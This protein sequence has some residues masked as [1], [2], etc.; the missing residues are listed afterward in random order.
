[1]KI[2]KFLSVL[3]TVAVVMI[4]SASAFA[5]DSNTAKVASAAT[6]TPYIVGIGD[7]QA[8]AISLVLNEYGGV[9]Y[10]LFIQSSTDSDWFKWTNTS[11]EFKR[12]YVTVGGFSGNGPTRAGLKI[13]YN[14]GYGETSVLY[15]DKAGT[16]EPQAFGNV[17][18]P[19]G[20]T[21]YVV[22]DAPNFTSP[23]A[24]HLN[25]SAYSI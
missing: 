3:L 5:E 18:V 13:N 12:V 16:S 7:T 4:P 17:F 10:D 24:Y 2:K 14:N 15:T 8:S 9:I 19:P 23:P 21:V 22:V 1:M 11:S 25:F 20:A 6:V